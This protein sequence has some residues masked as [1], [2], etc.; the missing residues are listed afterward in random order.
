MTQTQFVTWPYFLRRGHSD[1]PAE[2]AC[3]M[4]AVNWLAHGQHG[5]RPE[6]AC[7]LISSYVI[8]GNDTMPDAVRQ[9]LLP[10]LH[11]IAGSRSVEHEAARL[12]VIVLGVVR[13]FAPRALN[14]VRQCK[15]AATLRSLPDDVTYEAATEAVV[16][17]ARVAWA[18][19]LWVPGAAG[20][21]ARAAM[22]AAADATARVVEWRSIAAAGSAA[23]AVM[24]WDDYF[25][26]L[27]AALAAG[28]QGEAWSVDVVTRQAAQFDNAMRKE[29]TL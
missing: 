5:D 24:A 3:A 20:R 13:I 21:A 7:P 27:D 8:S 19:A 16:A 1:N 29:P 4:D 6:C 9:R 28:P 10:Y 18:K 15:H 14:I 11:R 22:G 25:A 17:A 12:R 2:G 23:E 26:V